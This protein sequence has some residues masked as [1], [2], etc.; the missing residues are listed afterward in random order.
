MERFN[1]GS[2]VEIQNV[3]LNVFDL[4]KQTDFYKNSIGL[5]VISK[6]EKSARLG[7]ENKIL[8]VLH[9]IENN[10][11]NKQAGL[12]H[13]AFL[14]PSRADLG[15]AYYHLLQ[16][17]IKLS[18]AADHGYSEAIYLDDLEGNGIEIYADKPEELWDKDENNRPIGKTEIMDSEGVLGC[19]REFDVYKVP[20]DTKVGHVH[21]RVIDAEKTSKLYQDVL[22]MEDKMTIVSASFI[23]GGNYHHHIAVNNWERVKEKR[24]DDSL[25]LEKVVLKI[26][27][28][29]ILTE[30]LSKTNTDA[31]IYNSEYNVI[32]VDKINNIKFEI[33]SI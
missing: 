31:E 13:T 8:L 12:Y 20:K 22:P 25:G 4:E 29:N 7:V 3:E 14:L 11:K 10:S 1:Y 2:N 32:F 26:V 18:G 6:D 24:E 33:T 16:S 19:K 5:E 30:I 9:K 21:L 23:A 15:A 27:N 28:Q 17:K